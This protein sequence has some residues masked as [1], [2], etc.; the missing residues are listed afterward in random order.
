MSQDTGSKV[1]VNL[2]VLKE[3]CRDIPTMEMKKKI[4]Q[5]QKRGGK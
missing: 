1:Y 3:Y 2:D 4:S 5:D